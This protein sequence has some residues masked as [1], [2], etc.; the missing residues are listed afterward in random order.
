LTRSID[1]GKEEVSDLYWNI[2]DWLIWVDRQINWSYRDL[3][4]E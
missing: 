4:W 2:S 1:Q 3:L